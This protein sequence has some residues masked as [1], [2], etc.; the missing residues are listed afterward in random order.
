VRPEDLAHLL[1]CRVSA[2][3]AGGTRRAVVAVR[4]LA[5]PP[6]NTAP[7]TV[8]SPA[9]A[10]MTTTCQPG[11]WTNS[12]TGV[13]VKWFLDGRQVATGPQLTIPDAY[14]GHR[15]SC[16][17]AAVWDGGTTGAV[18][19]PPVVVPVEPPVA[20]L[21]PTP[22]GTPRAGE[23][24]SCARGTWKYAGTFAVAWLR[25]G[26]VVASGSSYTLV[27]ADAGHWVSCRVTATGPGGTVTIASYPLGVAAAVASPVLRAMSGSAGPD[28]LTGGARNDLITGGAGGDRLDGG[29]GADVL[30]GGTG[31][32]RLT[33]GTGDDRL[34]GGTGNDRL[35]GGSGSDRLDGGTGNDRLT[36]GAGND[37]LTG[38][39]GR[40]RLDGGA[41]NDV[42]DARDGRGGDVVR[43]GSGRDKALIDRGDRVSRDCESLRRAR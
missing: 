9:R 3:N 19:S 34:T 7:P 38:G 37:R 30:L 5:G 18:A 13:S 33:G 24:L 15:L 10:G 20:M 27:A 8:A 14:Q 35:D 22:A 2:T 29:A 12:P 28:R 16:S 39:S 25:D 42:L 43:C 21:E 23:T 17:V 40:D 4:I 1:A 41:G 31:D 11:T 26:G 6:A 36:G 32:D